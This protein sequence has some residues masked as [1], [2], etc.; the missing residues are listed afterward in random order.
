MLNLKEQRPEQN[1]PFLLTSI[2]SREPG[3]GGGRWVLS[4]TFPV[5]SLNFSNQDNYTQAL[6]LA[7][8]GGRGWRGWKERPETKAR[9]PNLLEGQGRK[10][11]GGKNRLLPSRERT[12]IACYVPALYQALHTCTGH[13]NQ[14]ETHKENPKI[15]LTV[16]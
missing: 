3:W 9:Y 10:S 12:R 7:C 5:S 6:S 14:K 16:A 15:V 8:V 4:L 13:K 1:A 2:S 11:C